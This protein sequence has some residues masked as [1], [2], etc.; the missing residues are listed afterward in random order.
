M[1]QYRLSASGTAERATYA[2]HGDEDAE[3]CLWSQVLTETVP[4]EVLG[5]RQAPLVFVAA[6]SQA[7]YFMSGIQHRPDPLPD[8][9]AFGNGETRSPS[10]LVVDDV[11]PSWVRWPGEWGGEASPDSPANQTTRW[12]SPDLFDSG[13]GACS[14]PDGTPR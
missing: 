8:D 6:G 2:Q 3:S 10:L 12:S 9:S 11:F 4:D 1:V 7:S 14:Y 5:T 13:A